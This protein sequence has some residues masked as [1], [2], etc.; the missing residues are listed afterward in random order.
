VKT[1]YSRR[2]ICPLRG[3]KKGERPKTNHVLRGWKL[4]CEKP[5]SAGRK[6]EG[7]DPSKLTKP[8]FFCWS[9]RGG[10]KV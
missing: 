2:A 1:I 3:L 5:S 6:V 10:E 7:G 8:T 4:C 9:S